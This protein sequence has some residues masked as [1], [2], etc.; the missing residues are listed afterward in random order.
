LWIEVMWFLSGGSKIL[1]DG[2]YYG[3]AT[4]IVSTHYYLRPV[5]LRDFTHG[6]AHLDATPR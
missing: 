1:L 6:D 2:I 3:A 4:M 5:N